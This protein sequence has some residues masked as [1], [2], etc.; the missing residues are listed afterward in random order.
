MIVVVS[1]QR[2]E[3]TLLAG[4]MPC[5]RCQGVLRPFGNGRTRTVRGVGADTVTLT[6]RRARCR[7]CSATKILL[8]T[9][10]VLRRADSTEPHA[11]WLYRRAVDQAV[12]IDR[13]LLVR[14]AAQPTTLGHALNLLAGAAVGSAN[15]SAAATR[16][17]RRSAS[18]LAVGS[19]PLRG[20]RCGAEIR[21][22]PGHAT[23]C[24]TR[25]HADETRVTHAGRPSPCRPSRHG[26]EETAKIDLHPRRSLRRQDQ[27]RSTAGPRL[28]SVC[29]EFRGFRRNGVVGVGASVTSVVL[30]SSTE[31]LIARHYG[32][33]LVLVT[34]LARVMRPTS[35][36]RNQRRTSSE[37]APSRR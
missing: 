18:S 31:L 10:L 23:P 14:P 28:R 3:Q 21:V 34:P 29:R 33:A 13:E 1:Q 30:Q 6:P 17:G 25:H 15:A 16:S 19:W 5:P 2:A 7:D 11:Q 26:A 9:E 22:P 36:T 32:I 20:R 8:P 35:S 4:D 24:A 27:R 12:T 37:I